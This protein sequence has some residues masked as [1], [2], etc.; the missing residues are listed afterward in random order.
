MAKILVRVR[1]GYSVHEAGATLSSGSVF[2]IDENRRNDLKDVVD[3]IPSQKPPDVPGRKPLEV[4]NAMIDSPPPVI[5]AGGTLPSP[6]VSRLTM[7]RALRGGKTG[8]K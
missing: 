7:P 4:R 8:K 2:Q 5:E 3:I 6:A 1:Q